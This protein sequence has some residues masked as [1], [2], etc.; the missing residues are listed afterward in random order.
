MTKYFAK[1]ATGFSHLKN[2]ARCQDFSCCY[3]DNERTIVSA[4]DGHGG[5][6]Y[7]RSHL[8]SKFATKAIIKV[9]GNI[10]K[11]LFYRHTRQEIEDYIKLG[12]LCEW[13]AL[14]EKDLKTRRL[15]KKEVAHLN[16]K[17]IKG[18]Q[19]NSAKMYGT[20][21][22]AAMWFGN[23]LICVSL[24]DGGVF[25]LSKGNMFLAFNDEDDPVAN[26]TYSICQDDAYQ[27]L[28]VAL[29]DASN[30]DGVIV[31][32]DG[33]VNP[34]QNLSNFN[35]SFAK[36]LFVALR[37][38]EIDKIDRFVTDMAQKN[39]FGDDVSLAVMIKQNCS[40]RSY[41]DKQK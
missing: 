3:H 22:G 36:P 18:I 31:C 11:N 19:Q 8:G 1:S 17:Q 34:Y 23:K 13:N 38:G 4:C 39:G 29:F 12:I 25:I 15:H 6:V 33:L 2:G 9:L 24:G 7:I 40:L 41:K 10:E 16:E 26:F 14:V 35:Q 30:V 28:N 5:E 20:T 27:H 32:T 37:Q 21:L